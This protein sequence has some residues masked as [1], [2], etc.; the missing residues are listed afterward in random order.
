MDRERRRFLRGVADGLMARDRR[1]AEHAPRLRA[2]RRAAGL[3]EGR[4]LAKRF[5]EIDPGLRKVVLF[6]SL[7]TGDL[8]GRQPDVDLESYFLRVAKHF[9]NDLPP[10]EW[11]RALVERMTIQIEGLRPRLLDRSLAQD[12]H[13]LGAFRHV[14]RNM[15]GARLDPARIRIVQNRVP[16]TLAAFR[17]AHARFVAALDAAAAMI[18]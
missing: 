16:D 5:A 2:E 3:A 14:F 4:R 12:I 6:G 13:D 11:H 10:A 7:A 15:Y 17:S 8:R 9:E 1:R 18:E